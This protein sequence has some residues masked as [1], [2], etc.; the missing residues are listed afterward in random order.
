MMEAVVP[1]FCVKAGERSESV[2]S[3]AD[4]AMLCINPSV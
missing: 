3:A 4:G 1:Y 2:G